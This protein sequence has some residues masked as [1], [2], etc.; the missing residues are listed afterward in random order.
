MDKLCILPLVN[1]WRPLTWIKSELRI[2]RAKALVETYIETYGGTD[3]MH[4]VMLFDSWTHMA[5]VT[6]AMS[7]DETWLAFNAASLDAIEPT[8][9]LVQSFAGSVL[10]NF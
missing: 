3:K 5:E 7:T 8:A 6:T 2:R 9:I 4:Y 1:C 10:A